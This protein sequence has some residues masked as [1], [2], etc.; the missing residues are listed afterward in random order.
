[1]EKEAMRAREQHTKDS[2]FR[3]Q[4]ARDEEEEQLLEYPNANFDERLHEIVGF[5]KRPTENLNRPA[6]LTR[7]QKV[8]REL[9]YLTKAMDLDAPLRKHWYY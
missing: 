9:E 5:K 2:L 4:V 7:Y 1:M 8:Q 3:L 6:K